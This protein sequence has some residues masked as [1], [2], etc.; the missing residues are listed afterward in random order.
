MTVDKLNSICMKNNKTQFVIEHL[1]MPAAIFLS[2]FNNRQWTD[3]NG[4]SVLIRKSGNGSYTTHGPNE[5]LPVNFYWDTINNGK[6]IVGNNG[7]YSAQI[8]Q[9]DIKWSNYTKQ[10]T[11]TCDVNKQHIHQEGWQEDHVPKSMRQNQ[12]ENEEESADSN[13]NQS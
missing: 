11:I 9:I 12:S 8:T 13:L 10:L 2:I 1:T 3:A 5:Y 6:I 7:Y 4:D